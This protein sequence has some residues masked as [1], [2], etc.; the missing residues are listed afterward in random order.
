MDF[1]AATAI[2]QAVFFGVRGHTGEDYCLSLL[3]IIVSCLQEAIPES[4]Q[5]SVEQTLLDGYFNRSQIHY[6]RYLLSYSSNQYENALQALDN[7][8]AF[9]DSNAV[10]HYHRACTLSTND[11]LNDHAMKLEWKRLAEICH[12]DSYFLPIVYSRL[13][14]L[15]LDTPQLGTYEEGMAYFEKM[16]EAHCRF[17][18]LNGDERR[19]AK[20]FT[21]KEMNRTVKRVN[22]WVEWKE[23]RMKMDVFM[24][25]QP[26]NLKNFVTGCNRCGKQQSVGGDVLSKCARCKVACYCCKEC[27]KKVRK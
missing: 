19:T 24:I 1:H 23:D 3:D 5:E 10:F 11:F 17:L 21:E 14:H 6:F 2:F 27:Q 16:K 25:M 26:E 18:E 15:T 22:D 13:T 7:A 4:D 8:I 20:D 12:P 9:D